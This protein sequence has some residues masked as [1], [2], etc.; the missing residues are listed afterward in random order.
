MINKVKK[1]Y[2]IREDIVMELEAMVR[3]SNMDLEKGQK[4]Y[5]ETFFVE[6]G[7]VMFMKVFKEKVRAKRE[8]EVKCV[9]L[10]K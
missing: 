7:L 2:R 6:A 8:L 5:T 3:L 1:Q 9:D 4:G 10:S